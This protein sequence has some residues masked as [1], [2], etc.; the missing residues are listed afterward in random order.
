MKLSSLAKLVK[1]IK[2]VRGILVVLVLLAIAIPVALYIM[3]SSDWAQERIRSIGSAQLSSLLDTGVEIGTVEYSPFNRLKISNVTVAD[4]HGVRA[5]TIRELDTRFELWDLLFNGKIIID[6]ASLTGVHLQLYRDSVGAPLNIENIVRNL[7]SDRTDRPEQMFRFRLNDVEILSSSFTY[8]ILSA[9]VTPDRFNPSHIAVDDISLQAFA[10]VVS[11]DNYKVWLRSLSCRERSGIVLSDVSANCFIS[12]RSFSVSALRV[13]MPNSLLAFSDISIPIN[14]IKNIPASLARSDVHVNLTDDSHVSLP[15]LKAFVP[16]FASLPYTFDLGLDATLSAD[17]IGLEELHV[18][19][20]DRMFM[21][22]AKGDIRNYRSSDSIYSDNLVFSVSAD[23]A[24]IRSYLA[25]AHP[26]IT[27][28]TYS[29]LRS[30]GNTKVSGQITGSPEKGVLEIK[31]DN[32]LVRADL[33]GSYLRPIN[34]NV[35]ILDVDADIDSLLLGRIMSEPDLHSVSAKIKAGGSVVGKKFKGDINAVISH[36][37]YKGHRYSDIDASASINGSNVKASFGIDEPALALRGDVDFE[38]TRH[39]KSA[40]VDLTLEHA[41]LQQLGLADKFGSYSFSGNLSLDAMGETVDKL[42]GS[43]VLSDISA[44]A[45]DGRS[46]SLNRIEATVDNYDSSGSVSVASDIINGS[47]DGVIRFSTLGNDV[48]EILGGIIPAL[49][50]DDRSAVPEKTVATDA[51]R[52]AFDFNISD[53]EKLCSFFKIPVSIIESADLYGNVDCGEG[54]MFLALDAPW[55]MQ[56]NNVIEKTYIG[57]NIDG[58]SRKGLLQAA[59]LIPTKKGDMDV[60]ATVR[61][62]DGCL[63]TD[64]DWSLMRAIP[65]NG[66]IL[67]STFLDRNENGLLTKVKFHP[68]KI[69]FGNEI[70]EIAPANIFIDKNFVTVDNF[71]LN[72]PSQQ[73]L[74]DGVAGP[75]DS[76]VLKVELNNIELINIFETLEIDKA[77]ISGQA[78][79]SVIASGLLG[80]TP[81]IGCE[82]LKVKSIGYNYCTLGDADAVLSLDDGGKVFN[83]SADIYGDSG[84][85]ST[86]DGF[87]EPATEAIDLK[88][89]ADKVKVGFMKPFMEAFTS[90]VDGY[91]SGSA[92]LFGTFKNIDLTGKIYAQDL[93]IKIDFTNTWYNASDSINIERGIIK[94]NNIGI[95][96]EYGHTAVLDGW[97]AH[98]YFHDAS[99]H[100]DVKDA[101]DF[102]CYDVPQKLS[103]DWY[104][105]IFGNGTATIKGYPGVV[106]ISAN[107]T[108]APH[109]TFTFVLSDRLDADEY[110]FITFRDVTP[111]KAD[112]D[113]LSRFNVLPDKVVAVRGRKNS[114]VAD[115]PTAYNMDIGVDIRPQA[116]LNIIMDPIGGDSIRSNGN[117]HMRMTYSSADN[118]MRLYGTYT[119]EKGNYNFTLQDLIVKDLIIK[120]GSS[121]FFPGDPYKAK[122]NIEAY[123]PVNANLSDLDESFLEDKE[124]NRTKVPVRALVNITGD[125]LQPDVAFDLEFPTLSQDIYRKVRSIISTEDMMNRQIIYLLAINRFYTPEYMASTTKGNEL[126]SVVSSTISSRLSSMLGKLSDN[127]SIA[128]NLRSD[129]GDFSDLEVDLTLSS[130]L[131]NNRL[132]FNGNFGYRDKSLNTNQFVGDFD[133]EYLLNRTGDWRLKAY[134][135]YN[136]QNYYLRT[137]QTTQGVGIQ[138]RRDFDRTLRFLKKFRR[139]KD[140]NDD[141]SEEINIPADSIRQM[142]G[143]PQSHDLPSDAS[144][145]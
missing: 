13:E 140:T 83:F 47:V 92:N 105:R 54:S 97:V 49:T 46:L 27:P 52:F 43:F 16:F 130:S 134:N 53:T 98:K 62:H 38:E 9:P 23:S 104:G 35:T 10:P 30:L 116:E 33:K 1:L 65:I 131:L 136:D 115:T 96:D 6:Y 57:I 74:I 125:M 122:L 89:Q 8:D 106:D 77:L 80:K 109:S 124:L 20:Y 139:K 44:T 88:I 112:A 137:A 145:E 15:D 40:R 108:T 113:S 99:F 71:A 37:Y 117:G 84:N 55:I 144:G 39:Q 11:N 51:N 32:R 111:K 141:I 12:A 100:F 4:D 28:A 93:R 19:D 142:P 119:L 3:L 138:Y 123:Y 41:S 121:I 64:I 91:A 22:E 2:T 66:N 29:L 18:S 34:S 120:E 129:R 17:S 127:W 56:G 95:T 101:N 25:A 59:S 60:V 45:A 26:D 82:M 107:M 36:F 68:G 132:L 14:G 21:L 76:N 86:I 135:R 87:I 94:L 75:S 24:A 5:L 42:K 143:Y 70:W 31:T 102:L 85:V 78:T 63:D 103:P 79:G 126:F 118:D 7:V 67:F 128:P 90:D 50:G 110:S 58:E 73:I 81:S 61:G 69:N 48:K 72:A 114:E 133:I